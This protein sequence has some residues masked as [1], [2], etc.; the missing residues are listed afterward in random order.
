MHLLL[1]IGFM[2][3]LFHISSN[4]IPAEDVTATVHAEV[5]SQTSHN[6]SSN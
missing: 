5:G 4:T 6:H 2:E 3:Y 1:A